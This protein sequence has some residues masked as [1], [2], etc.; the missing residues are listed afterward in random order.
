MNLILI[1]SFLFNFNNLSDSI[2]S[3][4]FV[5][6]VTDKSATFIIKTLEENSTVKIE[7]SESENFSNSIFT[8]EYISEGKNFNFVKPEIKSLKP[9]T[10]YF[11][12]AVVNNQPGNYINSFKSFPNKGNYSFSFG[13]GSC[14]QSHYNKS[15]PEIF[16]IISEDSLRFFLQIG[17]WGYPDTTEK[18][19]GYRFFTKPDLIAGSYETKYT[20]TYPFADKVLSK[21]P[22]A[23]V[24]DDHDFGY[25][26][27]DGSDPS[28]QNSIDGYNI[29]FP[30]YELPNAENGLWQKFSFGDV[31]FFIIDTRTQR[32]PNKD[33]LDENGNYF[34]KDDH[35][36]L[37]GYKISGEDQKTWLK[38]S[39][40]NS[41]AKWKVI[42]SPVMF[43]PSYRKIIRDTVLMNAFERIKLDIIDKWSGFEKEQNEI[44][45]YIKS[46]GIENLLILSGDS[47]S[48]YIDD[49]ENSVFPEFGSSVLDV[50]NTKVSQRSSFVGYNLFNQ[51][52]YDGDG[53]CYGKVSFVYGDEDYCLM[54]IIDDTGKIVLSY[55]LNA[56]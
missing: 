45:D 14:Q 32:N 31:E 22:V 33:A 48:A 54:E 17:D 2:V 19:Y 49:G 8:D 12:R 47:H 21:M 46:E 3:G 11:Y 5:G 29:Y 25:N 4:P 15:K 28:K 50:N 20:R 37:A 42:V 7:L 24:Y 43:N 1:L 34:A 56:K 26:N 23:Y 40:K 16:K 13:F 39:L 38:K 9:N 35:S 52:G 6:A 18:K 27:S 10:K 44:I 36:I 53:R 51:G 55:K 41:K 30:H